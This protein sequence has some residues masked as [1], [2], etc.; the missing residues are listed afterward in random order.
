MS[1]MFGRKARRKVQVQIKRRRTVIKDEKEKI[2]DFR[3]GWFTYFERGGERRRGKE[4]GKEEEKKSGG[5][6]RRRGRWGAGC[7][8]EEWKT[9]F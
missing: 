3:F 4:E 2:A 5:E 8:L 7:G 6:K 9:L 1:K